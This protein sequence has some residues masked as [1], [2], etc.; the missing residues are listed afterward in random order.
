MV[1]ITK[2]LLLE[3]QV[4]EV[5][6]QEMLMV[7]VVL[8]DKEMLE[9]LVFLVDKLEAEAAEEKVPLVVTLQVQLLEM[10]VLVLLIV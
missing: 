2:T 5:L 3:D 10:V 7:R 8:Q 6:G 4:A 9:V 1:Q